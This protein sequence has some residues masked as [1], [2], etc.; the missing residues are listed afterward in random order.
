M[1]G[2]IIDAVLRFKDDFTQKFDAS[3]QH[4]AR[5]SKKVQNFGKDIAKVGDNIAKAG[6]TMTKAISLP[7]A[8]A[9]IAC[10]KLASDASET[11]S[12][13]EAVFG[14]NAKAINEWA[15][16]AIEKMGMASSTALDMA[17]TYGDMANGMG[18]TDKQSKEMSQKLVALTADLSSFKN[19]S[20][21]VANTAL[22]G[23]FTG[24][25]ESLKSL[26]VIMTDTTLSQYALSAGYKTAWK[27]MTQAEKVQ[28]RYNYVMEKTKTAQGDFE[29]TSSGAANQTRMLKERV[30]EIATQLGGNLLPIGTKLLQKVNE[31]TKRFSSLSNSQKE[32]IVKIAAIVAA[33][34]PTIMIF[35][36][37]TS[38]VGKTIST[39]GRLSKGIKAGASI[40]KLLGT[41]GVAGL[42]VIGLLAIVAAGIAIYKNWDKIVAFANKLKQK[43]AA[44][45]KKIGID[46]KGLGKSFNNLKSSVKTAVSHIVTTVKK[47][48]TALKPVLQFVSKVFVKGWKVAFAGIKG[49]VSQGIKGVTEIIKGVMT[50]FDGVITFIDGVFT[51]NWKK[52]WE[53]VK[54]IFGGVFSSL[55]GLVKTPFNAIIGLVNGVI[56]ALNKISVNIPKWVPKY[57]GKKFGFD[58]GK[59]PY[60]AKGTDNW[61]G[62]LAVT[63][64]RGGEL[65][66]LPRG[67][68]VYPHD[69]SIRR[70]YKDGE[71]SNKGKGSIIIKKLADQI[72]VRK[73]SDIDDI[74]EK[75]AARF[76]DIIDNGGGE[77]FV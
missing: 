14:D 5:N 41:G 25:G 8:G 49:Y 6:G 16:T 61:K 13:I 27:D 58:F 65:M 11:A 1:A 50:I 40:F 15:S 20:T 60:L 2:N 64:D 56:G 12:K 32:S 69:E 31:L 3:I 55:T 37:M 71:K 7:I 68:R 18:L 22:K 46:T 17:S 19:I 26:G 29:R 4:I 66:D 73:D 34:G 28:L 24:E 38:V 23:I 51:G 43:L 77:V 35:G 75:V 42:V 48:M 52:A 47:I 63:Q 57:G 36:K 10:F 54:N 76:I 33:V 39:V 44:V 74:V 72:V 62:G 59:I 67:T 45:F 21:D 9:G 70:A 30:K 53:G